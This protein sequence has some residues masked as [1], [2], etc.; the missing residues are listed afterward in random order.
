MIPGNQSISSKNNF[1]VRSTKIIRSVNS[2]SFVWGHNTETQIFLSASLWGT[3]IIFRLIYW[4]VP[5]WEM[6]QWSIDCGCCHIVMRFVFKK[7]WLWKRIW[8]ENAYNF[9][10]ISLLLHE[11]T[12]AHWAHVSL[13]LSWLDWLL[14]FSNNPCKTMRTRSDRPVHTLVLIICFLIPFMGFS[15]SPVRGTFLNMIQICTSL[16]SSVHSVLV[17]LTVSLARVHSCTRISS[18]LLNLA[19]PSLPSFPHPAAQRGSTVF[20]LNCRLTLRTPFLHPVPRRQSIA[21]N[22]FSAC[23]NWST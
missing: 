22:I 21:F 13:L 5:L 19:V 2:R 17:C 12:G 20:W 11:C 3:Q 18:T 14:V 16:L 4:W 10:V 23:L 8:H 15:V 9:L 6:S 7:M 1:T